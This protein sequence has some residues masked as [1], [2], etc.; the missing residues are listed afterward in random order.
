MRRSRVLEALSGALVLAFTLVVMAL[1]LEAFLR[2]RG[3]G[4][5]PTMR[6]N[7][8]TGWTM[9]PGRDVDIAGEDRTLE[10]RMRIHINSL[11]FRDRERAVAK[12]PGT[13]RVLVL[14][15]SF[16]EGAQ[17]PAEST[18][19]R[20]L[21]RA[22]DGVG[23]RRV[24]VWNCGVNGYSTAQ[25]LLCLRH[26]CA[27]WRP[28]L[29]VLGFLSANDV[30]DDVPEL[31]VTLGSRPFFRLE[32]DTLALDRSRLH[33]SGPVVTWLRGHSRAFLWVLTQRQVLFALWRQHR[34][35]P[36]GAAAGLPTALGLYAARPDST[37]ARAWDVTERLI[38]AIRDE[39]ARQ[40][41]GFLLVSIS[42][43]VQEDARA[44]HSPEWT[45]WQDDPA[46]KLDAP[47]TRLAA[48]AAARGIDYVPL[49]PEF[50]A[51]SA[52]ATR[53]FH[54]DWTGHWTSA[55]HALAA[56]VLAPRIARLVPPPR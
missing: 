43:G 20:R 17:V 49:L 35:A 4:D 55:G 45:R 21:D 7:P 24:E 19:T 51:A 28:D 13:F 41:A 34:P 52:A 37:W 15:D 25:E 29:V 22:L 54:I 11:G 16:V 23:G 3:I 53:P 47:E 56:R 40:G 5:D 27:G 18:M 31:A 6:P 38:V 2:W 9:I 10:P 30:G 33:P 39:A 12:A 50:R 32:A 48:L 26:V 8:W 14:G 44:R 42:S 36:G 46:L 1:G